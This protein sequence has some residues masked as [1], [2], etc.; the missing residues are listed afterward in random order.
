MLRDARTHEIYALICSFGDSCRRS[1]SEPDILSFKEANNNGRRLGTSRCLI[2]DC[3]PE[4]FGIDGYRRGARSR[5]RR[6]SPLGH[7][8]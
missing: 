7:K 4:V 3:V 2:A 6:R 8:D 1:D 5:S